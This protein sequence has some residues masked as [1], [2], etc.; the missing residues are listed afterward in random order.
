MKAGWKPSSFR[1][2]RSLRLARPRVELQKGST[3][4]D[5][6]RNVC[7]FDPSIIGPAEGELKSETDGGLVIV[8]NTPEMHPPDSPPEPL[9]GIV[10][11]YGDGDLHSPCSK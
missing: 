6:V 1:Y 4:I 5:I 3:F 11:T 8:I 10:G 2:R 9:L 7:R